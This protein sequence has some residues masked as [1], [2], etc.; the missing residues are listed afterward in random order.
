MGAG[1]SRCRQE[2]P[3]GTASFP[4]SAPRVS[5]CVESEPGAWSPACPCQARVQ[6]SA[7]K[8]S[9]G[10]WPTSGLNHSAP[11]RALL[12]WS[13]VQGVVAWVWGGRRRSDKRAGLRLVFSRRSWRRAGRPDPGPL[14]LSSA[15]DSAEGRPGAGSQGLGWGGGGKSGHTSPCCRWLWL[16]CARRGPSRP[17]RS[18]WRAP[19]WPARVGS[20]T[21]SSDVCRCVTRH[22]PAR[23]GSPRGSRART[24][25]VCGSVCGGCSPSRQHPSRRPEPSR[26][27]G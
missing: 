8:A 4:A 3:L 15:R 21:L 7:V 6:L 16:T 2:E 26:L 19:L 1:R 10:S 20:T 18:K 14:A 5:L 13:S 23:G 25:G 27:T 22:G 24:S 17:W 11:P 9:A 12:T